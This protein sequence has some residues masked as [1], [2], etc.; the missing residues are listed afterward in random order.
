M[1]TMRGEEP[2]APLTRAGVVL[3]GGGALVGLSQG[4]W[5]EPGGSMSDAFLLGGGLLLA[6]G[7][8]ATFRALRQHLKDRRK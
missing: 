2:E 8:V 7:V 3:V 6:G 1:L 4:G 5:V